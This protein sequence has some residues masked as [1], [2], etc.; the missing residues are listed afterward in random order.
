MITE[1][2]DIC[3]IGSGFGGSITAARLSQASNRSILVLEKGKRWR[4][5]DFQQSQDTKYLLELYEDIY[6][7]GIFIGLGKGVGGGSLIYS[8]LCFRTPSVVFEQHD[9][10]ENRIWP[11]G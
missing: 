2:V 6:G 1:K 5:D 7:D 9:A 11:D 3:I 8:S 4:G 10:H